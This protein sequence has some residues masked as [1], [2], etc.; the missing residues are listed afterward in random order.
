MPERPDGFYWVVTSGELE[1]AEFR[2]G[3]WYRSGC[4]TKFIYDDVFDEIG[5][6]VERGLPRIRV[7]QPVPLSTVNDRIEAAVA[8][9]REACAKVAE[10]MARN[11]SG[12]DG[13]PYDNGVINT[14]ERIAEKIR[15]RK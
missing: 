14:A 3:G 6:R 1:V 15:E 2:D 12:S 7:D 9:E 5:E 10:E 13:D 11:S 4:E 8:A